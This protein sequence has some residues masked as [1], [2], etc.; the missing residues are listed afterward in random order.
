VII[1]KIKEKNKKEKNRGRIIM[2]VYSRFVGENKQVKGP[3]FFL[4]FIILKLSM[5]EIGKTLMVG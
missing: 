5:I 4:L 3:Y 2:S 1:K